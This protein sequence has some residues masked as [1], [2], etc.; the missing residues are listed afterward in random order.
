VYWSIVAQI[1][2]AQMF[3]PNPEASHTRQVRCL[4]TRVE[5]EAGSGFKRKS[6]L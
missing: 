1:P 2:T 4:C 3:V 5:N 6:N